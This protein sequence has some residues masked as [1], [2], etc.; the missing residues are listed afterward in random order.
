MDEGEFGDDDLPFR[1]RDDYDDDDGA[2]GDDGASGAASAG[3]TSAATLEAGHHDDRPDTSYVEDPSPGER[4]EFIKLALEF[5][6]KRFPKAALKRLGSIG[7]SGQTLVVYTSDG[8]ETKIF[9]GDGEI[10]ESFTSRFSNALGPTAQEVLAEYKNTE[11]RLQDELLE[12]EKEMQDNGKSISRKQKVI[13]DISGFKAIIDNIPYL[14][15]TADD[16]TMTNDQ[17]LAKIDNYKRRQKEYENKLSDR[18]QELSDITN[19][20]KNNRSLKKKADLLKLNL[21]ETRRNIKITEE[22]INSTNPLF[23]FIQRQNNVN[24]A[25]VRGIIAS[26]LDRVENYLSS[27][28]QMAEGGGEF[29]YE[30][31]YTDYKLD[32]DDDGGKL[33]FTIEDIQ[34]I[35]RMIPDTENTLNE[36][37]PFNPGLSS[38][39]YHGGESYEMPSYDERTPLIEK[40]SVEDIERR[41]QNL[42]NPT[43][44]MLRTDVPPPP[45]AVDLIDKD[46]EIQRARNF[47]K[48]RYPNAQVDKLVLQFSTDSKKPLE[49]VVIGPRGGPTK[50]L[51]DDGSGLQKKFLNLAFVKKYL[52]E[53]YEELSRKESQIIFSETQKLLEDKVSLKKA[54]AE[55]KKQDDANSARQKTERIRSEFI[56]QQEERIRVE[57]SLDKKDEEI[58]KLK[59]AKKQLKLS[60]ELGK[61][62]I[63]KIEKKD[64]EIDKLK[65][66]I[67]KRTSRLSKIK[68]EKAAKERRFFNTQTLETIKEKEEELL[69]QNQQDQEIIQDENAFPTDREAAELRVVERNE[70]IVRLQSQIE[71]RE[72]AMPLRE[73]VKEIFKKY[74]VT[75][76]SIFLA[77]GITIGAVI[78]TITSGLKALGKNIAAGLK[79]LGSQAASALPGLIGTIVSFLFKTAGQAIG[80]LAEH[81]WLL[82]L[83]VVAFIFEKYIKRRR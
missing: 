75:V 23:G 72:T 31:P 4:R 71:E 20:E 52:G 8:V 57:E 21:D 61:K 70:E 54:E 64:K 78:S 17:L 38:T 10:L 73:R 5:I 50:V 65:A 22:N 30:D 9:G 27:I 16:G 69:Q 83:A 40:D 34:S 62:D 6:K 68:S 44:G 77:A 55:R 14:I 49:I 36:T 56:S 25:F 48:D 12:T 58:Q 60:E 45:N 41:L 32:K 74:G 80:F 28:L 53:S 66:D 18:Q 26:I 43:T 47:I 7:F 37:A 19:K 33:P 35:A 76:T 13:Q 67:D 46:A 81:T 79:G 29:G 3:T 51:L 59:E 39:P 15:E 11:K 42:R 1:E 24:R 82:I 2:R 63:K